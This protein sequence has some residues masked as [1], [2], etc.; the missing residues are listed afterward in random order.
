LCHVQVT[1]HVISLVWK[2]LNQQQTAFHMPAASNAMD[3][4]SFIS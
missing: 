1:A 4:E 3:G 2:K